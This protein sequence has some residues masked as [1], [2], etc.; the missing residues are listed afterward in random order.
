M[1]LI[2]LGN[3]LEEIREKTG[4]WHNVIFGWKQD[5]V[6]ATEFARM[7]E[8][9]FQATKETITCNLQEEAP[10]SLKKIVSLRDES[11]NEKIQLEASRD[12]L[13]RAGYTPVQKSVGGM[14]VSLPPEL[15]Q[16]IQLLLKEE[17]VGRKH[18]S[19]RRDSK[20]LEGEVLREPV[21]LP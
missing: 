15:T 9:L 1:K 3:T 5:E 19:E 18:L 17:E 8:S 4:V 20:V 2:L 21:L 16:F 12:L 13:D 7:R 14:T 10:K 6:W 11:K